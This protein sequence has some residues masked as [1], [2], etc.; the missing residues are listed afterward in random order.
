MCR[1]IVCAAA[2]IVLIALFAATS[3]FSLLTR[4]EARGVFY[5]PG[6]GGRVYAETRWL[7]QSEGEEYS[8][9]AAKETEPERYVRELLL[10]PQNA[11]L[12]PLFNPQTRALVCFESGGILCVD[13]SAHALFPEGIACS[14]KEGAELLTMN[15]MRNFKRVS[16]VSLFIGGKKAFEE[17]E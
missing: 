12:Q 7:P 3:A 8:L 11:R 13:L 9:F 4:K 6:P 15:V 1:K 16:R 2:V 5:F 10:G 14:V 17:F